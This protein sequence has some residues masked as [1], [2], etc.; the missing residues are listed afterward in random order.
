MRIKDLE[1]RRYTNPFVQDS[2]PQ[3][4]QRKQQG[5]PS[6]GLLDSS[7]SGCLV[8]SAVRR[9]KGSK[10]CF[11][12]CHY[13]GGGQR[14]HLS[15]PLFAQFLFLLFGQEPHGHAQQ[16]VVVWPTGLLLCFFLLFILNCLLL[17]LRK[18]IQIWN[19]ICTD[20]NYW[21]FRISI[22]PSPEPVSMP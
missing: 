14:S 5:L 22:L 16:V 3:A 17:I 13:F 20:V 19:A 6:K 1:C 4:P 2:T 11:R 8:Q 9:I 10:L 7:S 15:I 18:G 12:I 21:T